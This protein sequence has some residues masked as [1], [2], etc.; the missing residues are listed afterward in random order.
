MSTA[1]TTFGSRGWSLYTGLTVHVSASSFLALKST[2]A[3]HV[4]WRNTWH[5]LGYFGDFDNKLTFTI[6]RSFILAVHISTS[7]V[8]QNQQLFWQ[9]K[10]YF[11]R[12]FAQQ[13]YL[14]K[15]RVFVW[16]W[17]KNGLKVVAP[18]TTGYN[19]RQSYKRNLVLN[20]FNL[21]H[22]NTIF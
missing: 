12:V 16:V 4:S 14:I 6:D 3:L 1:A 9:R 18:T 11:I 15:S 13:V 17:I 2:T 10:S 5:H 20:Y 22:N 19:W 7:S 21:D 8:L